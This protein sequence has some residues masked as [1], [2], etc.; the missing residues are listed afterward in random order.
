[1][2]SGL[3]ALADIVT[4]FKKTKERGANL[5][6]Q[7][8]KRNQLVGLGDGLLF[9]TAATVFMPA[10]VIRQVRKLAEMLLRNPKAPAKLVALKSP[11]VSI[12]GL[13]MIPLLSHPVDKLIYKML[14]WTYRP[15]TNRFLTPDSPEAKAQSSVPAGPPLKAPDTFQVLFSQSGLQAPQS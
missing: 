7:Q 5:T 14:D 6:P 12:L 8:R 3:Y 2:A 11:I 13:S 1:M 9:H 15:L 10:L 4:S